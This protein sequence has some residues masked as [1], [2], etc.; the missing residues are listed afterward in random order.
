MVLG[1]IPARYASVRLPGKAL[2][3]ICGKPMIQH[4]W[5]GA[6]R[7]ARL[8][9]L[10]VATD[11]R[12]I[13]DAVKSFGGEAVMTAPELPSGTDR[14]W[15]AAKATPADIILNIQGDE[16]LLQPAL[17]DQ[18]VKGIIAESNAGMVTLQFPMRTAEGYAQRSVVKVVSDEKGWAL[19]FS[20]SP[21]PA[22]KTEHQVPS[23]WYK[24]L[25]FYAYRRAVLEQF[26]QWPPSSLELAEGLEQLRALEHGVRI[27]M[28][29]SPQD[30]VAVDTAE[31][32]QRV[33]KILK[34]A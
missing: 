18:L 19:Y 14:V 13:A 32:L 24:H 21:I 30:T 8:D 17:V 5:E 33:E 31:D 16:P 11:D 10:I 26:V 22:G 15:A 34:N 27:K 28:I 9:R 4:V 3:T 23:V 12:R 1:V 7:S 25:G 20:R 2:A 29:D 6:R